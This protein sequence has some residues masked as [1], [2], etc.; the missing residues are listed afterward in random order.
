MGFNSPHYR[1]D[2]PKEERKMVTNLTPSIHFGSQVPVSANR[3][4]D[5]SANGL[6]LRASSLLH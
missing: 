1:K 5:I 4:V 6:W 3:F 2:E